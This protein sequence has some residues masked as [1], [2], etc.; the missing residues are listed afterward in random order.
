M[1]NNT[2]V[3]KYLKTLIRK[4]DITVDMTV[5]GGN[6][7]LFLASLAKEVIGFD[8]SKEALDRAEERLLG[9]DNVTLYCQSHEYVDR[10]VKHARFFLFNLGYYPYGDRSLPTRSSSTLV[11]FK[12]AWDLLEEGGYIVIT[13]YRGHQGGEEEYYLLDRYIRNNALPVIETYRQY[14]SAEEPVTYILKKKNSCPQ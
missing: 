4:E 8:I 2:F 13:F 1:N 3:H 9:K 14:R 10:Y 7:T 5:G 11:A 12:K 6:D